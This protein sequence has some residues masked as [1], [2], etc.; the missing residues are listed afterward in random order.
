MLGCIQ[1]MPRSTPCQQIEV[2][3]LTKKTSEVDGDIYN[4]ILYTV[5]PRKREESVHQIEVLSLTKK[6]SEVDGDIYNNILYTVLPRKR[7]ES[8]HLTLLH[9]TGTNL[10]DNPLYYRLA[11]LVP[12]THFT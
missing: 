11:S 2:L 7:E 12:S 4:N 10:H 5:L 8:V 6:T 1:A 9:V 3:T